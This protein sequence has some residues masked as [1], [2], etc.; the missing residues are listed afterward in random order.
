MVD[1]AS[2]VNLFVKQAV[3]EQQIPFVISKEIYTVEN[4]IVQISSLC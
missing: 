3:R 4:R 1:M 2:A